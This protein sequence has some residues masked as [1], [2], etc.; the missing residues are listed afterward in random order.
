MRGAIAV[1]KASGL[2]LLIGA[3]LLLSGCS[4]TRETRAAKSCVKE[5]E[6]KIEKDRPY[7]ADIAKIA[8][9][10]KADGSDIIDIESEITGMDRSTGWSLVNW[11][12]QPIGAPPLW[13]WPVECRK[14]GP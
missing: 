4:E 14:R 1:V 6:A 12:N 2:G 10:A 8:A 11:T 13:S 9:A 3:S 5:F 7:A